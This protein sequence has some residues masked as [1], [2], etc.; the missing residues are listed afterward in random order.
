MEVIKY[1]AWASTKKTRKLDYTMTLFMITR[2][3]NNTTM[4][5]IKNYTDENGLKQGFWECCFE[6][7]E[8]HSRGEYKD[9][10]ETGFWE[11]FK[12]KSDILTCGNYINGMKSGI[13]K[14][15]GIISQGDSYEIHY[16]NDI[17]DGIQRFYYDFQ[18]IEL[19]YFLVKG[20]KCGMYDFY[21]PSGYVIERGFNKNNKMIGLWYNNRYKL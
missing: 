11:Y 15:H 9:D 8:L 17:K 18:S 12:G 5:I 16:K 20:E 21:K 2:Q 4:D 13:W 14:G 10:K 6:N 7:G 3:K 1:T 19:V